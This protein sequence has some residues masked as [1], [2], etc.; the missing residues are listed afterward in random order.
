MSHLTSLRPFGSTS[1]DL[2]AKRKTSLRNNQSDVS[3][4]R[5]RPTLLPLQPSASP[6]EQRSTWCDAGRPGPL[7]PRAWTS[8]RWCPG[9]GSTRVISCFPVCSMR[10]VSVFGRV[11]FA[12]VSAGFLPVSCLYLL[13][14]SRRSTPSANTPSTLRHHRATINRRVLYKQTKQTLSPTIRLNSGKWEPVYLPQYVC[15]HTGGVTQ[16]CQSQPVV[17]ANQTA[18]HHAQTATCDGPM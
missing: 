12:R 5:E 7:A 17:P 11:R 16:F 15:L 9:S 2:E 13:C 10:L 1:A 4:L 6:A 3:L 18:A 14:R 8:R